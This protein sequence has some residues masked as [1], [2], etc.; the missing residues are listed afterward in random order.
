MVGGGQGGGTTQAVISVTDGVNSTA[1]NYF[2]AF[3]ETSGNF[4][5]TTNGGADLG[6][7]TEKWGNFNALSQGANVYF[8][9]EESNFP[10]AAS[11]GEVIISD[12]GVYWILDSITTS[13]YYTIDTGVIAHFQGWDGS[14][15][16]LEY[17]GTGAFFRGEDFVSFGFT[18]AVVLG[19]G[20][21]SPF[22]FNPVSNTGWSLFLQSSTILNFAD[23]GTLNNGN[24]FAGNFFAYFDMGG[25]ISLS[26]MSKVICTT[27]QLNEWKN[28]S[29]SMFTFDGTIG[30]VLFSAVTFDPESNE[31][32][33]DIKSTSVVGSA[34]ITG[35]PVNLSLGGGVFAAGSDDQSEPSW[36]FAGNK[37][38]PDST[39]IA[40]LTLGNE[41]VT[42]SSVGVP[43]IVNDTNTG[44]TNIWTNLD[45]ERFTIDTSTG[46][47]E[48]IGEEDIRIL[49]DCTATVEK[50]GGG[51]QEVGIYIVLNGAL[52]L[53]S[54][55]TTQNPQPTFVNAKD[56][57]TISTGDIF[58]IAAINLGNANDIEFK[59]ANYII[60]PA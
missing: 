60:T 40:H 21:N 46:E 42:I 45:T 37:N 1:T 48:Y 43:V 58:Q 35:C 4:Q 19:D 44:G 34:S 5:P 2:A 9:E 54:L 32:V 10:N 11:G 12:S 56:L 3:T 6:T 53:P 52:Q 33:F 36:K 51:N 38:I 15:A 18:E 39:S 23:G 41:T 13:N 29:I 55:S 24:T 57:V 25:T 31:T 47:V 22:E 8:I 16:I 30:S 49:P 27:A 20:T 17:T 28:N 7:A 14:G 59:R 26:N 50:V